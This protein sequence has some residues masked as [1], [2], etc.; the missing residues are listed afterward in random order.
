MPDDATVNVAFPPAQTVWLAGWVLI[1][2]VA[3]TVNVAV[4]EVMFPQAPLMTTS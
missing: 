3:L 2:V 4:V 1:T